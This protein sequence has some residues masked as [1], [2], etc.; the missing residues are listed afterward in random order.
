MKTGKH[1][2]KQDKVNS[3]NVIDKVVENANDAILT[4]DTN[5]VATAASSLVE[6]RKNSGTVTTVTEQVLNSLSGSEIDT[7]K[8]STTLTANVN[9]LYQAEG[10][11]GVKFIGDEIPVE[12]GEGEHDATLLTTQFFTALT[13]ADVLP[14]D[15]SIRDLLS[16]ASSFPSAVKVKPISH[17]TF[18]IHNHFGIRSLIR[19]DSLLTEQFIT[20]IVSLLGRAES[21]AFTDSEVLNYDNI[22]ITVNNE[23]VEVPAVVYLWWVDIK[24]GSA[25]SNVVRMLKHFKDMV[26]EVSQYSNRSKLYSDDIISD[27]QRSANQTRI[28]KFY[29]SASLI[30]YSKDYE[31]VIT[32]TFSSTYKQRTGRVTPSISSYQ[33]TRFDETDAIA[34]TYSKVTIIERNFVR[35][36]VRLANLVVVRLV[37]LA[38]R[39]PL[40]DIVEAYQHSLPELGNDVLRRI[41]TLNEIITNLNSIRN[42]LLTYTHRMSAYTKF[43][44]VLISAGFLTTYKLINYKDE[45]LQ[46][47]KANKPSAK[48][49]TQLAGS[50]GTSFEFG[51]RVATRF[52]LATIDSYLGNSKLNALFEETDDNR[53]ILH[54]P[55]VEIP[56]G[57][58]SITSWYGYY[59]LNLANM[60]NVNGIIMP[61]MLV[62]PWDP[63]TNNIQAGNNNVPLVNGSTTSL[64]MLDVYPIYSYN[65]ANS[66]QRGV[67]TSSTYYGGLVQLV[68]SLT[69]DLLNY[70]IKNNIG[71]ENV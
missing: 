48:F 67:V 6:T 18:Y 59:Y 30:G 19:D 65:R 56:A 71:G 11:T 46:Y 43:R 27:F 55:V 53:R 69:E 39:L 52:D 34:I 12:K 45:S 1:F 41:P 68:P 38:K 14:D 64:S 13:R 22:E 5:P 25:I 21:H 3:N 62:E 10:Y 57:V 42:M 54:N 58:F 50:V 63:D 29:D 37:A 9:N 31:D 47:P 35:D 61:H 32:D 2:Q 70:L 20:Q 33:L 40:R 44:E 36:L 4:E 17:N 49:L 60:E 8:L 23:R 16:G 66:I 28:A 7:G 26:Y 24:I 15:T 51:I